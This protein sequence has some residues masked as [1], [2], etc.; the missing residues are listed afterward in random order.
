MG[1]AKSDRYGELKGVFIC[2]RKRTARRMRGRGGGND[3]SS[4]TQMIVVMKHEERRF[5]E[6]VDFIT[7]PGFLDGGSTRA[8]SGLVFGGMYR[9]V[10]DLAILNFDDDTKE[11]KVLALHPGVTAEQVYDNTG[12]D[13][14]IDDDVETTEPPTKAELDVLRHLDPERLYI[15]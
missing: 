11:M 4:L 8:E 15:A 7:S 12:F 2:E 5:V 14:R 6:K 1:R 9:V 13:I 3:I 10:T